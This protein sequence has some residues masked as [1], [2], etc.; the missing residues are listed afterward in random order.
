MPSSAA[1]LLLAICTSAAVAAGGPIIERVLASVS[2]TLITLGDAHAAIAM[3]LVDPA[4]GDDPIAAALDQLIDRTLMLAEVER[5]A[6]PEPDAAALEAR[7][8]ELEGRLSSGQPL[9]RALE[10]YGMSPRALRAIARDDLRLAAYIDQRFAPSIAATDEDVMLYYRD[11]Q[12]EFSSGGIVLPLAEVEPEV[13][14][15]LDAERRAKLIE[16]WTLGL[17]LR[18]D[19]SVA[20][21]GGMPQGGLE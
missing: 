2:G 17:R 19:V 9:E 18:A 10:T 1:A 21:L 6:P 20:Y 7:L 4:R 16:E 13:R 8:K 15:R 14:R 3:G 12:Q 11:H 5:Y